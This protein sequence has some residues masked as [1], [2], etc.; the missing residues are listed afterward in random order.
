M[1]GKFTCD[2][3]DKRYTRK[4]NMRYHI[5]EVHVQAKRKCKYCNKK[6]RSSSINRHI[7]YACDQR[8]KMRKAKK[9]KNATDARKENES[10]SMPNDVFTHENI[11]ILPNDPFIVSNETYEFS[12]EFNYLENITEFDMGEF[13]LF[14]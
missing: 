8:K 3:C 14:D 10:E 4:D 6:M 13:L 2:I 5:I 12:N 9:K 1:A 11:F 7:K